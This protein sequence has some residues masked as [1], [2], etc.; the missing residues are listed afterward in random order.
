MNTNPFK[1]ST[2][3]IGLIHLSAAL[4]VAEITVMSRYQKG[5]LPSP[6]FFTI[7]SLGRKKA[8]GWLVSDLPRDVIIALKNCDD[9]PPEI[10]D[11]LANY[12]PITA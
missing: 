5:H 10:K 4:G 3:L 2:I 8:L 11:A 12:K 1:D 6:S 9:L 7:D